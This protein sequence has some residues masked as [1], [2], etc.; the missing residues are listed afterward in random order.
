MMPLLVAAAYGGWAPDGTAAA[1]RWP[2]ALLAIG[3]E[4]ARVPGWQTTMAVSPVG[5]RPFRTAYAR[6]ETG[7]PTRRHVIH[8][9]LLNRN[10]LVQ[11][12]E[13]TAVI[14]WGNSLYGTT[15]TT[16]PGSF[17][18]GPGFPPG[19]PSISAPSCTGTGRSTAAFPSTWSTACS[20]T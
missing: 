3:Q 1:T 17:S 6:L 20:R 9:D 5:T 16:P 13:I 4:T 15:C 19:R 11:G 2:Q 8:Q 14:D 12:A 18:G 7:L 10:V